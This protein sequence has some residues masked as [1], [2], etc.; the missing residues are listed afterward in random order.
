MSE[1]ANPNDER[2][3]DIDSVLNQLANSQR[4]LLTA[5]VLLN[6]R[7]SKTESIVDRT[8]EQMQVL[9]ATVQKLT[10]QVQA[11]TSDL[12]HTDDRIDLLADI[13]R[14]WIERNGNGKD[15]P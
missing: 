2:F 8:A 6:D 12:E 15:K 4:H 9:T 7:L 11:L 3:D 1:A 5:Q 10:E 14:Q 13:V